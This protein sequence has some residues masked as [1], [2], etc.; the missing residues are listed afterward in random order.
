[1]TNTMDDSGFAA[2]SLHTSKTKPGSPSS[3]PES[4][5]LSHHRNNPLPDDP[6][7][8]LPPSSGSINIP[9]PPSPSPSPP[10]TPKHRTPEN[11]RLIFLTPI[12]TDHL[13]LSNQRVHTYP[14]VSTPYTPNPA[15][16]RPYPRSIKIPN[17][18]MCVKTETHYTECGHTIT[19]TISCGFST[20]G[21]VRF[22]PSTARWRC[23]S[24][25]RRQIFGSW[26]D[27][28]GVWGPRFH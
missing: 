25:E 15:D 14:E 24:C 13:P 23:T 26:A 8:S 18:N 3:S 1:M 28:R 17:P 20:C 19:K 5:T 21:G 2:S 11:P 4:S 12:Y 27:D 7:S 10:P 9:P 6:P 22:V 16:F